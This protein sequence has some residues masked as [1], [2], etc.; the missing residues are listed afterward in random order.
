MS[1]AAPAAKPP[2]RFD[3]QKF[4]TM[5]EPFALRVEKHRGSLKHEVT[6][7]APDGEGW[8]KDRI[9]QLENWLVNEWSGGGHYS[10]AITDSSSPAQTMEWVS[11]YPPAD[12][13]EKIPPTLQSATLPPPLPQL[14]QQ[15]QPQV[16]QQMAN[17]LG[18]ALPPASYFQQNPQQPQQQFAP[19]PQFS[20]FPQ[21]LPQQQQ[22]IPP[23]SVGAPPSES[24][25]L[26][27][28]REAL[29]QMREQAAQREFDRRVSEMKAEGDRRFAEMQQSMQTMVAQMT[30]ALK[31]QTSRPAVDPAV[32]QIREQNR[33][34]E[35]QLRM[36][37]AEVE[38][39][40]R[41]QELREQIRVGQEETRRLVEE[42]NRRYEAMAREAGSKG[43]D[44]QFLLMMETMKEI[45]RSSQS[46]F[47]RLQHLMMR[48]QDIMQMAKDSSQ[49]ADQIASQVGR[50]YQDIV[51]LQRQLIE[52]A[53]QLNQGGGNEVIGLVR[54]IGDKVGEWAGRYTTGKS[55]EA[56]ESMR[57]QAE[58]AKANAEA[59]R[60]TQERMAD[61]ARM[62]AS[63]RSGQAA[64]M[65][66]GTYVGPQG[67]QQAAIPTAT[68]GARKAPWIA[69][70][71]PRVE[72]SGLGG[73]SAPQPQSG[74]QVVPIKPAGPGRV[75]KGK[76]EEE[77]FGP[78]LDNVI[79]LR[80][81]V[82]LFIEGLTQTPPIKAEKSASPEE[83]AMV[84]NQ[85]AMEI[86]KAQI[87]ILAINVLLME[88]MVAD[89]LDVLLPEAPQ[90]YRDDVV[91]ILT[92][93]EEDDDD[94]SAPD[95][96]DQAQA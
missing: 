73:A 4:E 12:F 43:P 83:C 90:Q 14:Q 40:R 51:Q 24:A 77:W 86:A 71:T 69:P 81:A 50:T 47:D 65:S 33:R 13:P 80:G 15:P 39:T 92:Q 11:Y 57:S 10:F 56:V 23:S 18:G 74:G 68:N 22:Y 20:F 54:D 25:E 19:Q 70:K 79:E 48:P 82:D 55:K 72:G 75:I 62:E 85:A 63:I 38:R 88:G 84:I 32:E 87:P 53:A 17:Q 60:M 78:M 9:R 37:Q 6:P 5:N 44:P 59:M 30:Q 21:S 93:D 36:Q 45:A 96:D 26:R 34:L 76:T 35:E 31:E 52:Q 91:Q 66:N 49:G 58:V 2:Q 89:F 3:L 67:S 61:M 28:A 29:A 94:D 46:Q 42:A 1:K 8:T 27:M 41:E 64:S 95:D 7:P 16:K